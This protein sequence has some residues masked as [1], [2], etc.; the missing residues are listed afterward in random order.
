[1]GWREEL[2]EIQDSFVH[3]LQLALDGSYPVRART[4]VVFQA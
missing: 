2:R 4:H 1:M 3:V